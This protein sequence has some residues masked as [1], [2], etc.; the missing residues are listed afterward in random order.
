MLCVPQDPSYL[1]IEACFKH[2]GKVHYIHCKSDTSADAPRANTALLTFRD[3]IG[4]ADTGRLYVWYVVFARS[5]EAWWEVMRKGFTQTRPQAREENERHSRVHFLRC[6]YAPFQ[7]HLSAP[8]SHLRL[9]GRYIFLEATYAC[10]KRSSGSEEQ[11]NVA[12][13]GFVRRNWSARACL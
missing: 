4:L 12:H 1:L 9:L 3:K 10:V 6:D 11:S 2:K 13:I 8:S 7:L 5:A